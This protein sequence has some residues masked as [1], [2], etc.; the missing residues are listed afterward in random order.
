M[1]RIS[2]L[3]RNDIRLL[4]SDPVP[5]AMLPLMALGLMA[6]LKS[7]FR[8]V[9]DAVY[10]P[11]FS[12][13]EQ[14]VPGM[15][16]MFGFFLVAN[17]AFGV[18]RE[19]GWNT[20][21]RLRASAL[22]SIEVLVGKGLMPLMIA[23]AYLAV[24]FTAGRFLFGLHLR[25]SLVPLVIVCV[26]FSVCLASLSLAM[27]SVARTVM[28]VNALRKHHRAGLRR[29]GGRPRP[30][31]SVAGMGPNAGTDLTRVLGYERIRLGL[32]SP[33]RRQSV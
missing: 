14:A 26:S 11:G 32:P 1:R 10:G 21:T 22:S 6:F 9:V 18:F 25:G 5:T 13:A 24:A 2:A 4:L 15:A 17:G 7:T 30:S 19:H 29:P 23:V 3:V 12:G 8:E 27:V 16:V 31:R 28:Q 20:W 33:L